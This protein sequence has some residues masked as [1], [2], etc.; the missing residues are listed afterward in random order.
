M[1]D[2]K[3]QIVNEIH[4]PAYKNFRRRKV[5]MVGIGDTYEVDLVEMIPYAKFNRNHKYIL[6][7]I[8]IFSK[9]AFAVALKTKTGKEV[10][11]AMSTILD[12]GNIPKNIHL[13]KGKEF[14]NTHFRDLM[15][16]YKINMYST[17]S[18]KKASIVERFN[19][20]LKNKMWKK[21]HYNGSYK[22]IDMITNLV[23]EYN[24]SK[25]RTIGM[26]PSQVNKN[27]ERDVLK[28]S[29]AYMNKLALKPKYKVGDYIRIS[30]FKGQF[31]K[32]YEPNWTTEI[33]RVHKI[34]FTY[35]VT[36]LLEDH[37]YNIIQGAFYEQEMQ[38]VKNPDMYLVEK[39]L[40]KKGNS[41]YVK[42]LGFSDKY[43]EWINKNDVL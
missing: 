20:T 22:W 35:P 4:R 34:Q 12:A 41:V 10:T 16:R 38:K 15:K 14:Y 33:F 26:K 6:T 43:N 3:K 24:N 27:N 1:S 11:R 19:R 28:S 21:L 37:E 23:H 39:I 5:D 2:F 7:C 36:Y 40:K 42:W 8:D 9:Q 32:G 18:I 29:Y 13:D 17:N 30:K 25:H 31:E